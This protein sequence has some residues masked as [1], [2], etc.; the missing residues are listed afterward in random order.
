MQLMAVK[1][2]VALLNAAISSTEHAHRIKQLR[3]LTVL[4]TAF[5]M[6]SI[7]TLYIL[8]KSF[9]RGLDASGKF[10]GIKIVV[11]IIL[12]QQVRDLSLVSSP[13]SRGPV[14]FRA[15]DNRPAWCRLR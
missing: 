10:L 13:C 15:P 12:A 5:A 3:W 11:A 7:F 8:M 2:G 14:Q 4:A 9:M 6:H 1:P